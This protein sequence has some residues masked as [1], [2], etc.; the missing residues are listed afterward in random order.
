MICFET[1]YVDNK[2][3]NCII[4]KLQYYRCLV[5]ENGVGL[6]NKNAKGEFDCCYPKKNKDKEEKSDKRGIYNSAFT[7][8]N[9]AEKIIT[10]FKEFLKKQ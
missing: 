8:E 2:K 4:G 9:E 7:V 10:S 1:L 3:V 5:D 6:I